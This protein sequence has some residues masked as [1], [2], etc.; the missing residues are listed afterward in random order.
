MDYVNRQYGP[1]NPLEIYR[2]FADSIARAANGLISPPD[3]DETESQYIARGDAL[4][5]DF[6]SNKW[7]KIPELPTHYALQQ[8][9]VE[10]K[11][12][13]AQYSI[14]SYY[15]GSYHEA[16]GLFYTP[17][18]SALQ[19]LVRQLDPQVKLSSVVKAIEKSNFHF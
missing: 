11:P 9:A 5:K 3:E 7:E 1:S 6:Q 19:F 12:L 4:S 18:A 14:R 15:K 13:W 16:K 17:P 2:V 8:A 10:F